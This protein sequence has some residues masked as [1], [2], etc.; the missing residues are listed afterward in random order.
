M[1]SANQNAENFVCI[2]ITNETVVLSQ[3]ESET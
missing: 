1:L 2:I 3:W